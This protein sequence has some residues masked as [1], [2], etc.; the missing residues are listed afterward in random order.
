MAS[1]FLENTFPDQ[2]VTKVILVDDDGNQYDMDPRVVDYSGYIMNGILDFNLEPVN[3][4]LTIPSDRYNKGPRRGKV[5][6]DMVEANMKFINAYVR[7]NPETYYRINETGSVV[8]FID[9]QKTPED[10]VNRAIVEKLNPNWRYSGRINRNLRL[11][12]QLAQRENF[13]PIYEDNTNAKLTEFGEVYQQLPENIR[14]VLDPLKEAPA[15]WASLIEL[16]SNIAMWSL[17][18]DLLKLGKATI[19]PMKGPQM[20]ETEWLGPL[21]EDPL[22]LE[23]PLMGDPLQDQYRYIPMHPF[24]EST[25][26]K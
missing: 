20:S 15:H 5:D 24:P 25:S 9:D 12:L 10:W 8:A 4:V 7:E 18:I 3:G 21:E 11:D 13:I 26:D 14:K 22:P 1:G 2:S 6:P 19:G 17:M 23:D 16:T